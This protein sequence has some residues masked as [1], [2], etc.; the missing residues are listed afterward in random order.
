M[1][2][3]STHLQLDVIVFLFILLGS[4]CTT[5]KNNTYDRIRNAADKIKVINTQ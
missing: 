3:T 4:Q 2:N 1:K 5:N